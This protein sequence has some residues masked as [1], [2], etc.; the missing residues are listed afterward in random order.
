MRI[1]EDIVE[2]GDEVVDLLLAADE[3]REQLD[4]VDIVRRHL[5]EDPVAMEEGY[6]HHLG[7]DG[8]TEVFERLVTPP[9]PFRRRWP[10]LQPDHQP[11][12]PDFVKHLIALDERLQGGGKVLARRSRPFHDVLVVEGRQCGEP[13]HHGQLV[14][15]ERARVLQRF[16]QRAEDGR[17]DP[18]RGQDGANGDIASRKCLGDGDDVGFD[19]EC[20]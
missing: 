15:T 16:L 18:V 9:Q 12:P 8:G 7:E 1:L 10:E 20:S 3:R 4:D 5:G 11:F 6:D 17:E 2:C 13:G 14:A 19:P